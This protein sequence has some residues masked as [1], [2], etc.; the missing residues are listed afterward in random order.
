[1]KILF[2]II[3][4]FISGLLAAQYT[5]GFQQE[6][7]YGNLP[8]AKTEAL[9]KA[10]AAIGGTVASSFFNS[11]GLGGIEYQ[12]IYLS[13]SAPFYILKNS[14][15]WYA[16]Y[17]RRIIPRIVAAFS[18][19]NFAIGKTTFDVNIGDT[20]YPVTK[21]LSS[22][23][24]LSVAGTPLKGLYIGLNFNLFRW[25]LFD[26]VKAATTFH[27]DGGLHYKLNLKDLEKLRHHLQFG[28]S[29]NNFV[30]SKITWQAPDGNEATNELPMI[31]RFALAYMFGSDINLPAAGQGQLDFTFTF[32][33]A[34]TFNSD[35]FN[36][37]HF[38]FETILYEV[39]VFRIGY[40]RQTKDDLGNEVN[41]D[42]IRDFTYGFG[43]I[44]PLNKITNAKVPLAIFLDYCSLKPPST[45]DLSSLKASVG[46]IPN[47]R[48]F[49]L[50]VAWTIPNKMISQSS[51]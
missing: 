6:Y 23:Y 9:G 14:N 24:A 39:L 40:F 19:N 26:D 43:A 7:F 29:V 1:M 31:G 11:A 35:Y 48:T 47:L 32:E 42:Y 38:G 51:L 3:S 20:R 8:A 41:Y 21:G 45:S 17:A 13:Q 5:S 49:T 4:L 2:V 30:V 28:A 18:V 34:A 37:Y 46:R 36:S 33:Y 22:N 44:V 27:I 15:Y 10:D 25:K 12:E 50:R 16:G